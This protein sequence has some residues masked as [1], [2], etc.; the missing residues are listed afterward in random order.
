[1]RISGW[2]SDVC[3]SDLEQEEHLAQREIV[4]LKAQRRGNETVRR[5]FVRQH[6]IEPDRLAAFVFGAAV[7]RLHARRPAARADDEMTAALV[8]A[9]IL[10]R[11]PRPRANRNSNRL[12]SSPQCA[13][14]HPSSS[15]QKKK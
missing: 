7:R 13:T 6:D 8:V 5:L 3:S 12:N 11:E 15:I 9:R 10:A 4:E 14:R 1:M 2:S